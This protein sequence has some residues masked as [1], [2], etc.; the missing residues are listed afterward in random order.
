[1]RTCQDKPEFRRPVILERYDKQ[2]FFCHCHGNST[3][4]STD[5][6]NF[7][8]TNVLCKYTNQHIKEDYEKE[9]Q[10]NQQEHSSADE[11]HS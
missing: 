9:G 7:T 5:L 6:A 3:T 10:R 11:P 2:Q 1:M 4:I 8:C